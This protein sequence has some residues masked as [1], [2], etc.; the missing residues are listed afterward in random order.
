LSTQILHFGTIV[1][2]SKKT[3]QMQVILFWSMHVI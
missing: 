1:Y 3:M 2:G